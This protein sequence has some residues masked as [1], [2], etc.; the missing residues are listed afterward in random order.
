[1]SLAADRLSLRGA[2][3]AAAIAPIA[4]S[5]K[6]RAVATPGPGCAQGHG[7]QRQWEQCVGAIRRVARASPPATA[8]LALARMV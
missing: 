8:L 7:S 2:A 1:M 5:A 3:G 4:A 6:Y